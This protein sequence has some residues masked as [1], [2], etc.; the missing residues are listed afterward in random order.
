MTETTN[1][2]LTIWPEPR[3]MATHR[4][5]SSS[6]LFLFTVTPV[7]RCGWRACVIRKSGIEENARPPFNYTIEQQIL[8]D[9][10]F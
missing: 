10:R 6:F 3:E 1:E 7:P 2:I 4:K 8:Q 5:H 9:I